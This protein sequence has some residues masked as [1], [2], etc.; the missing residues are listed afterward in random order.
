MRIVGGTHRSRQ[1]HIP[2]NLGIR[3]TTDF[4]KEALFNILHN[5]IDFEGKKVLDLFGGSG[6][7][8]YE[9]ASRGCAEITTIEKNLKSCEFIKKTAMEFKL[10]NIKVIKMDV[11]SYLKMCA[12]TFDILFADPPF[13]LENIARIPSLV[14]EQKLLKENGILIV[15]HPSDVNFSGIKELKETREYGTVNFSIFGNK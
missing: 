1:F 2:D 6:S 14:F 7:I 10:S 11:F 15:E 3:P 8:S 4:A 12:D 9:F 5:R 13:K